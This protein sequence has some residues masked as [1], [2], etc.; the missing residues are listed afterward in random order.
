M[1]MNIQEAY[2]ISNRL[3]QKRNSS[4][5]ITIKT[6]NALN[7]DKNIKSSKGKCQVTY[8]GRPIRMIP[9]F[10]LETVKARRSWADA[11]DPKRTQMPAHATIPSKLSITIE[12]ENKIFHDKTKFT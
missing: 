1:S 4:S 10:L 5:Y 2:R 6:P 12:G 3:D 9:D 7:K 8:K 11:I